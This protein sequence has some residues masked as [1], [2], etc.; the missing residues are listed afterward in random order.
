MVKSGNFIAS[1][2]KVIELCRGI[3]SADPAIEAQTLYRDGRLLDVPQH[4][5]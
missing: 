3:N 4:P 1:M 2:E 5:G